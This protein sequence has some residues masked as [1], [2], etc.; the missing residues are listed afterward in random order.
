MKRD[1]FI[2][3]YKNFLQNINTND[4]D[5]FSNEAIK[6]ANDLVFLKNSRYKRV[7]SKEEVMVITTDAFDLLLFWVQCGEL[8]IEHF[9]KFISILV[10]FSRRIVVPLDKEIATAM[11]EMMK[12][13]DF[14]EHV[15]QTT[16]ELY[17][18]SPDLLRYGFSAEH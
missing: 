18:D 13:I 2:E 14:K 1:M 5:F 12:L 16:I 4:D 17:I 10:T 3:L 11:I 8:D 9:E 7:I 6:K 15:V